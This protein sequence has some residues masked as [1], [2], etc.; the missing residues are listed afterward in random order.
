MRFTLGEVRV[1]A[2]DNQASVRE[3]CPSIWQFLARFFDPQHRCVSAHT[4]TSGIFC[5]LQSLH[6][7]LLHA[8]FLLLLTLQRPKLTPREGIFIEPMTSDRKLE[9]S[10]ESS[11]GRIYGT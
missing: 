2:P 11:K 9:A 1:E 6:S 10:R 7:S 8:M 4:P 5:I 3:V